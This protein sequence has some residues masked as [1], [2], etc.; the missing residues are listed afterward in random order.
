MPQLTEP[1]RAK[2]D[3]IVQRM[4]D[5]GESDDDIRFVVSDFKSKYALPDKP[6]SAEDF[7][8][9]PK[10]KGWPAILG[11]AVSTFGRKTIG[12]AVEAAKTLSDLQR[13]TL[14]GDMEAAQR[15]ADRVRGIIKAQAD[16][17]QKAGEAQTP[18]EATA[19][20][21]AGLTPLVGPAAA[22]AGEAIAR[23]DIGEGLGEGAAL[24]APLGAARVAPSALR[25]AQAVGRGAAKAGATAARAA[26]P[27]IRAAEA[28]ERVPVVGLPVRAVMD[29]LRVPI[30]LAKII[31]K[32]AESKAAK[33]AAKAEVTPVPA[34]APPVVPIEPTP[35]RLGYGQHERMG[36]GYEPVPDAPPPTPPPVAA[37]V[38]PNAGGAL[39]R[40]PD[41]A[42]I[43]VRPAEAEIADALAEVAASEPVIPP[44]ARITTPPQPDLPPGYTPRTTVPKPKAA[45]PKPVTDAEAKAYARKRAAEKAS[46][47]APPASKRPYFLR[48]E[49][50]MEAIRRAKAERAAPVEPSDFTD[51]RNLP[52]PWR[53]HMDQPV[54]RVTASDVNQMAE[55]MT[56]EGISPQAAIRAVSKDTQLPANVRLELMTALGKIA[57][58][59]K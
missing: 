18:T 21:F 58:R 52:E 33:A 5:A 31:S 48:S 42:P 13:G 40:G 24:L 39:R 20:F 3:G 16:Q 55:A 59:K 41:G 44:P 10:S 47:E 22:D 19:H 2:L 34:P 53:Q 28:I 51:A 38:S 6:V 29:P 43:R 4:V 7:A 54:T 11:D 1:N 35:A 49:A 15:T 25:G 12:G 32:A 50:D 9:V 36:Y 37:E 56:A 45:K 57:K 17:F 46:A 26:G 14:G 8:P 30:A 23:G 27:A